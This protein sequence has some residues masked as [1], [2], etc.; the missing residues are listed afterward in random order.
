MESWKR[1]SERERIVLGRHIIESLGRFM[2]YNNVSKEMKRGQGNSIVL[3]IIH[4]QQRHGPGIWHIRL[5]SRISA[6]TP[7]GGIHRG[8]KELK[9]QI[10]RLYILCYP[11][12]LTTDISV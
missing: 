8:S 2:K 6:A 10:D 9:L 5:A 3:L 7:L 1:R 11:L 12:I 4:M